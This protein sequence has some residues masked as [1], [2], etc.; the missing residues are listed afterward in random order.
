MA[1]LKGLRRFTLTLGAAVRRWIDLRV[2]N[3]LGD[4]V[5]IG[6]ARRRW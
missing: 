2:V 3:W 1:S 5:G 6:C 4:E